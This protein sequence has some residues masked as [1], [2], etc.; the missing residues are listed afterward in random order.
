M[1]EQSKRIEYNKAERS[2]GYKTI[3][4]GAFANEMQGLSELYTRWL[5]SLP[6]FEDIKNL[7]QNFVY[8]GPFV[9]DTV[10]SLPSNKR[11]CLVIGCFFFFLVWFGFCFLF[12]F[13]FLPHSFSPVITSS[14]CGLLFFILRY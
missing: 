11:T 4:I 7:V 10:V 1:F 9:M 5:P 14:Y 6:S 8:T 12:C 2:S 13:V 3:A